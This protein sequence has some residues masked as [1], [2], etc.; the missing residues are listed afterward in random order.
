MER[1]LAGW[2]EGGDA[3]WTRPLRILVDSLRGEA[4]LNPIG[5][6]L[7]YGQL[8][9]AVAARGRAERLWQRRPEILER[10][11]ERPIVVLGQMRSGTT[12]IHRLLACDRR[13]RFTRLFETMTPVPRRGPDLRPTAAAA[14]IR[15][16]HALNPELAAVHP[17]SARAAEEEFGLFSLSFYGAQLEA[18]WRVPSFAAYWQSADRAPVYADFRRLMQT[19]AWSRGPGSARWIL[20]AP[21]FTEDLDHL[22]AAFPDVRLICLERDPEQVVASSAS[23]VWNQ[24]KVQSDAADRHWI[25]AEW[26]RKTAHREARARQVR[27]LRPD[28]PQ[29]DLRFEDVNRDWRG[30]MRRVYDFLGEP[31]T[32]E[33]ERRMARYLA[34]AERSGFRSHS[35]AL[36]DFGLDARSVRETIGR[37]ASFPL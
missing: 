28:V 13:F 30:E 20:K 6:T 37:A 34:Q 24:M 35:Y 16:L 26:L 3:R 12:R 32:G 5:R 8:S 9:R 14:G 23:L 15:F 7:A 19:I 18:Q 31:L 22:L 25:G 27:R 10:R 4:D 1:A 36:E 11:L 29:I 2:C 33:T 21:Q 17:T